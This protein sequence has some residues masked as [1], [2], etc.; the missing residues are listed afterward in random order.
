MIDAP[1][2]AIVD[3]DRSVRQALQRLVHSAGYA[4]QTFG[5]AGEFLDS[6]SQSLPACL[7]LDIHLGGMSG[8][9]LQERLTADGMGVPVIFITAYDDG[10]TRKRIERSGAAGHLW[11]PLDEQDLLEAIGRVIGVQEV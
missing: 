7:I 1:A 3:D 6:L 9:E 11:K 2:I 5:S 10:P 4:V 8:F